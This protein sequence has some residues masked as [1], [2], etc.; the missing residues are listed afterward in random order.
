MKAWC[1][2]AGGLHNLWLFSDRSQLQI[3]AATNNSYMYIKVSPCCFAFFYC[4][5]HAQGASLQF[6]YTRVHKLRAIQ[7]HRF[8]DN[9]K[10]AC[11][12]R[13]HYEMEWIYMYTQI[14]A[15]VLS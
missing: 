15:R 7:I 9:T 3:V 6:F 8:S 10:L 11:H 2:D 14:K 5:P 1:S 13:V 4:Q 12:G